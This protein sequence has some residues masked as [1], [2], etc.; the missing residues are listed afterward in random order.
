MEPDVLAQQ[1]AARCGDP[2]AQTEIAFTFVV[3]R[4]DKEVAR[5]QFEW[6]PQADTLTVRMGDKTVRFTDLSAKLAPDA[7]AQDKDDA[8]A[9]FVNDSYWLLAP[10]KVLD[11]GVSRTLDAQGRLGLAFHQVG[12][13]PG[14]RYWLTADPAGDLTGWNY[15]LESGNEGHWLWAPPQAFGGLRLSLERTKQ[16]T[17]A[18]IRFED[19]RVR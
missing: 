19:V 4:D 8:W 16:G 6:Q 5:R 1:I 2:Y 14:D 18:V 7:P 12:L 10:C 3:R 9:A 13:T 11:P 17:P 15:T